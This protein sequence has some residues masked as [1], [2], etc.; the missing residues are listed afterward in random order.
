V[1]GE[2]DTA[3]PR[4]GEGGSLQGE[5]GLIEP[6]KIKRNLKERQ[7]REDGGTPDAGRDFLGGEVRSGSWHGGDIQSWCGKKEGL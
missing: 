7:K 1:K 5:G 4:K 2:K 6:G 3:E